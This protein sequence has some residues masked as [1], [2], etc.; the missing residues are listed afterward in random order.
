MLFVRFE[1]LM[2]WATHHDTASLLIYCE[3]DCESFTI[4]P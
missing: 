2:G 1:R 4:D 3:D